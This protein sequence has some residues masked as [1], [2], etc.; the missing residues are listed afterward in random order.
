MGEM[1]ESQR[2]WEAWS[3]AFSAV[4]GALPGQIEVPCPEGD[5][6]PVRVA[7]VVDPE[8]RVGVGYAWCDGERVGIFLTRMKAPDGVPTL[9]VDASDEE[10]AAMVPEDIDFLPR[11]RTA[12][13]GQDTT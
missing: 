13:H 10:L 5:G 3:D 6:R 4:V 11:P 9:P 7:F 2:R 8:D 12:D 1:T